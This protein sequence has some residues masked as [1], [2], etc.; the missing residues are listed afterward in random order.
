MKLVPRQPVKVS[1]LSCPSHL[2]VVRAAV[3][4][5]CELLGFDADSAGTVVLGM[6]EALTNIIKHAYGGAGDKPIDVEL[7]PT[8]SDEPTGLEIRL[9]DR[10]R[11]IDPDQIKSRDLGD[12]RP[13]GL[14][15]HI[16]TECMD[17]V[18]YANRDGGGTVLSLVKNLHPSDSRENKEV[19][20]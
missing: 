10:G 18:E 3:E 4:K 9:L 6:D 16:I 2:P 17:E 19:S 8:G 20:S 7:I 5:M 13:G 14:G 1:I 15:V 12:V 11:Q